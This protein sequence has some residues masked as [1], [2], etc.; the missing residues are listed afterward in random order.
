MIL[1]QGIKYNSN[2]VTDDGQTDLSVVVSVQSHPMLPEVLE[3]W[4]EYLC[5][6]VVGF[7]T[8][9]STA[10]LHHL[11]HKI[12]KREVKDQNSQMTNKKVQRK[13]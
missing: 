13:T 7:N 5:L 6:N 1:T 10:L 11:Q 2:N 4:W 12:R 9:G 8:I 3:E